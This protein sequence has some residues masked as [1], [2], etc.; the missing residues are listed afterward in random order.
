MVNFTLINFNS[1]SIPSQ[2]VL[3]LH[4][5]VYKCSESFINPG[6]SFS[7]LQSSPEVIEDNNYKYRKKFNV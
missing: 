6:H 3:P 7:T 2:Q 1:T 4:Q 5:S